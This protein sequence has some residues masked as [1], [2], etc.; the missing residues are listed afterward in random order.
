MPILNK[1]GK[2]RRKSNLRFM[3]QSFAGCWMACLLGFS[4]Y[5]L[6]LG[7]SPVGFLLLLVVVIEAIFAGFWQATIVSVLACVCLDYLFDSPYLSLAM[8]APQDWISLG[9][10]EM[11]ALI[12]SRVSSR[13]QQ[14]SRETFL[15]RRLMEQLYE[16]SRSLLF[17]NL[18]RPPGPQLTQLIQSIF[19][20]EVVALFDA[21]S[22]ECVVAGDEK[23]NEMNAAKNCFF[24][25]ADGE[26]TEK[27]ITTRVLRIGTRAVG[28]L[29]M[30]GDSAPVATRALASLSAIALDR[31][32]SLEKESQIEEAHRS[33]RLRAAVLDS[34][35]HAVKTPL[36]AIQAANAGLIEVGVLND[37]Q[38]KLMT[39][40]ES[41]TER[42][43]EL[44]TR[45]LLTARLDADGVGS[46]DSEVN[47]ADLVAKVLD[48]HIDRMG[49]HPLEVQILD[50]DLVLRGDAEML[51]RS[52]S[53]FLD[54]AVKYS[55]PG[56]GVKVSAWKT[57]SEITIAVHNF[58]PA[59]LAEERDLI[60]QRFYRSKDAKVMA[61]GTGLGLFTV[62]MT[63]EAHHG[64][65]WV[66]SDERE[67]TTFYLSL[68]QNARSFQ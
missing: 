6:H 34:L 44:C 1:I 67:G 45:L 68:P 4:G 19:S 5:V 21:N 59:I 42:L 50:A 12:V 53:E 63:A 17:I 20:L 58:G 16:L 30:R 65:A 14:S 13:A 55:Y 61:V 38:M 51:S 49:C 28:A 47:A 3:S 56:T 2:D 23:E 26:D 25:G 40:V 66:I 27:R 33:E 54:N 9:T 35:A 8:S 7:S 18:R 11:T 48:E 46:F 62:R 31:F 57:Q 60:F 15:Q 37:N 32:A 29:A 24:L 43:R 22:G 36:T 39:L 41:E 10:F 52:L 64:H